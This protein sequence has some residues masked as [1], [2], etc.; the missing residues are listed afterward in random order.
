MKTE[1]I[2]YYISE[3]DDTRWE[4]REACAAHEMELAKQYYDAFTCGGNCEILDLNDKQICDST[5]NLGF[6][7]FKKAMAR[8]A[9]LYINHSGYSYSDIRRFFQIATMI[10][11]SMYPS[12][13]SESSMEKRIEDTSMLGSNI[14]E[15]VRDFNSGRWILSDSDYTRTVKKEARHLEDLMTRWEIVGQP[16]P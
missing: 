12:P 6:D 15:Y 5:E 7:C 16:Y 1:T 3:Y 13:N 10:G 9:K 4:T 11:Q 2:T 8:G 14:S